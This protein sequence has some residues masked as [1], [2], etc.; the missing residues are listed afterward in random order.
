MHEKLDDTNSA[1]QGD[2]DDPLSDQ[3][4]VK[5]NETTYSANNSNESLGWL[6]S[7][8]SSKPQNNET[9]LREALE[10]V[11]EEF[12]D[13]AEDQIAPHER[14]LLSNILNLRDLT[15][16]DVMIP[17]ADIVAIPIDTP[18]EDL[19]Q[20]LSEKQFSRLP[21]YKENMDDVIG[22]IHIKDMLAELAKGHKTFKIK[23]LVRSVPIASPSMPVLDLLLE[24]QKTTKHVAMVVDE[25]GGI[26][27]LV[28]INDLV[29][30]IVGEIDDEFHNEVQPTLVK[31]S[32][33]S[34]IADARYALDDF[35]KETGL[36][37]RAAEEEDIDTLGGLIFEIAGRIPARGEV[38][39]YEEKA[40]KFEIIEADPRRV[41]KIKIR[42][43]G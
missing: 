29:E 20:L 39:T 23:D 15:V 5:K 16:T 38:L 24:M 32:D 34:M 12:E 25:Y 13:N 33:G 31:N 3:H 43:I 19:F 10:E 26:D 14:L 17:R 18:M 36:E 7:L 40:L 30:S 21:V 27:G 4:A 37:I 41:R 35:E 8:V 2:K 11:I 6:K 9:S 22:T 1:L 28:T 42:D